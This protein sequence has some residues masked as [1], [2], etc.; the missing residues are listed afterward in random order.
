MRSLRGRTRARSVSPA[1][2]STS[3]EPSKTVHTAIAS[4]CTTTQPQISFTLSVIRR[5]RVSK[6]GRVSFRASSRF[7]GRAIA[8]IGSSAA[9]C[10][11]VN[12][13]SDHLV[14]FRKQVIIELDRNY[15]FVGV[16]RRRCDRAART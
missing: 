3:T 4:R 1:A 15:S 10:S 2:E 13:H 14:E 11:S 8:N 5:G 7:A 9:D 16:V 6:N 12:P